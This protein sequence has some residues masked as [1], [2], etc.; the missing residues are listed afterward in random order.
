ME[1]QGQEA[2]AVIGVG[3]EGR[4]RETEELRKGAGFGHEG[5]HPSQSYFSLSGLRRETRDFGGRIVGG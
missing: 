2:V 3:S 1:R 4:S 5:L